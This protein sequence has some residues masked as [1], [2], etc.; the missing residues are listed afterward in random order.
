M[1][2]KIGLLELTFFIVVLA[3]STASAIILWFVLA[4][5]KTI[6]PITGDNSSGRGSGTPVPDEIKGWNFGAFFFTWIWGIA[7]NVWIALLALVLSPS[8]WLIMAVIL[9]IKG[10]E[11]AW[12]SRRWDSVEQ[13]KRVQKAWENGVFALLSV[14]FLIALLVV[15]TPLRLG[16]IELMVLLVIAIAVVA[17]VIAFSSRKTGVKP[18]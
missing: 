9:G 7:N 6:T 3:V 10:N 1:P 17:L 2:F 4:K 8:L 11:W 16:P 13:F 12:R 5:R 15:V 14:A 18:V